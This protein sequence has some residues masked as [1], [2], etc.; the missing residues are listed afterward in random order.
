M[1]QEC[2]NIFSEILEERTEQWL[3][4]NYVP[5]A[6]TY[7]LINMEMGFAIEK[8]LIIKTDKK[9]G[10]T[11]GETDADFRF[12]SYLDYYSKLIEMNKPVDSTKI[13][14]SNN[15]YSFFVK[16]ESL[17]EK[18][19]DANIDGYYSVLKDP[20]KKYA[21]PN[22]KSL[23]KEIEKELG[24]VDQQE[25]EVI[26]HWIKSNLRSL[27]KELG[28][29]CN[30]KDY[31]KIFFVKNDRETTKKLYFAEG[32]RYLL[33]NIYN[34]ND[35]NKMCKEGI[36]GLPSNNIGM[37]SKKPYLENKTRKEKMPYMITIDC[38]LR[39]MQFF[40]YLE[41]QAAKGKCNIYIECNKK[42]IHAV[43]N[44]KTVPKIETGIY[45][46]IQQGKE[47]II[48]N[49]CRISSYLAN[50]NRRFDMKEVIKIPDNAK[51]ISEIGYGIKT[52][53][54]EIEALVD[55]IFFGKSLKYNYFTKPDELSINV[56]TRKKILLMYREQLWDWFYIG[57]TERIRS[58]FERMALQ[59]IRESAGNMVI[60]AKHQINLLI[61]VMDY[62]NED[63][64]M[65]EGMNDVRRLLKEHIDCKQEWMFNN[66]DEYY[67][68]VGQL[69][70]AFQ[71]M[72]KSQKKNLSL[73]NSL[74]NSKN[75]EI[76]KK[77][78]LVLFQKYNYAIDIGNV[79]IKALYGHIMRYEPTGR[80]NNF[81]LSA[82]YV[83]SNLIYR[84]KND[85]EE[86]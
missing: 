45:L 72:S 71:G 24:V 44:E 58:I 35:F 66:D 4:D 41:G 67:Y 73:V 7:I 50:L 16:K 68:A 33:P 23:Y 5:K 86:A 20:Y 14:H 6:G 9:T 2:V 59:L 32:K 29:D 77:R 11:Q 18:L 19:G 8:K 36:K 54:M 69:L 47:L 40:D 70:N 85:E 31:L 30:D 26:Y 34:K 39:Q 83:D 27:L 37:N 43:E 48:Q 52:S 81:L 28:I 76:I 13:I 65:E 15:I 82:G 56:G 62:F 74:L 49:M 17:K 22:D 3:L 51:N 84:K 53:L 80:A 60:K 61:S 25:L 38:A 75:D 64:R 79:R 55:N 42:E 57:N 46:R 10:D 78:L 21:K 12:I 63:R 1:L